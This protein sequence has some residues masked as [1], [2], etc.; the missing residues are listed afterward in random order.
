M[1]YL[2]KNVTKMNFI[3]S[4]VVGKADNMAYE[5]LRDEIMKL[6]IRARRLL[7]AASLSF[8]FCVIYLIAPGTNRSAASNL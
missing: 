4:T 5:I 1:L 2:S 7:A 6:S 8:N 3:T